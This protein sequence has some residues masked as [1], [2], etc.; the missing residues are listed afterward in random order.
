MQCSVAHAYHVPSPGMA[1]SVSCA[2]AMRLSWLAS[3]E[4][5]L[6]CAPQTVTGPHRCRGLP[7]LPK[8][9]SRRPLGSTGRARQATSTGGAPPLCM[10]P[11]CSFSAAS[12]LLQ[13][14]MLPCRPPTSERPGSQSRHQQGSKHRHEAS[15]TARKG[16]GVPIILVPSAAT[17]TINMLN[18]KVG[19][20]RASIIPLQALVSLHCRSVQTA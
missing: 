19:A 8:A 17:A 18:A 7:W 9:V 5:E 20:L 11:C 16:G 1:G 15:S 2:S 3:S 14:S 10:L 12:A 6:A 4:L 13:G